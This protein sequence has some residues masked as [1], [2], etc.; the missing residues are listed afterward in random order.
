MYRQSGL[1]VQTMELELHNAYLSEESMR[2]LVLR[3]QKLFEILMEAKKTGRLICDDRVVAKA[4]MLDE[5]PYLKAMYSAE[6]DNT[7]VL[8]FQD[9]VA[10]FSSFGVPARTIQF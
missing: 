3:C 8:Y 1:Q 2:Q 7:E 4:H 10:A 6:N 9:A 5:Y